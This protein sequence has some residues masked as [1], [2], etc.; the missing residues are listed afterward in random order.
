[1]DRIWCLPRHSTS[2]CPIV[3]DVCRVIRAVDIR[4][5]I[6]TTAGRSIGTRTGA[7]NVAKSATVTIGFMTLLA[8]PWRSRLQQIRTDRSVR[9][10]AN[11]TI[12]LHRLVRANKRPAL[13]HMTLVTGV[14]D[15]VANQLLRKDRAMHVVAV[16]AS[17]LAL[18]QRMVRRT[19][20]L[21][22]L[23]LVAT[24]TQLALRPLVADTIMAGVDLVTTRAGNIA[25]I[26]RTSLPMHAF[27][28]FVTRQ[29]GLV[30]L[31]YRCQGVTKIMFNS[32]ADRHSRLRIAVGDIGLGAIAIRSFLRMFA[33]ITVTTGATWIA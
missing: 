5:T 19:I 15:I 18:A 29:A 4:M 23:L 24:E 13:L 32:L 7:K 1:M 28:A 25:R 33:A 3:R 14:I 26:M 2:E 16:G 21:Y 17:H 11:R 10:V 12:F 9:I 8:D 6:K 31:S 22:A 27:A 30:A 20:D